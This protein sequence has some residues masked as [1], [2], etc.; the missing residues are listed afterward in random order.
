MEDRGT[1]E[2]QLGTE[3]TIK[4][5]MKEIAQKMSKLQR[6][7]IYNNAKNTTILLKHQNKRELTISDNKLDILYR[8]SNNESH[9]DN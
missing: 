4:L 2:I 7:R 9:N 1:L 6:F 3:I 5:K 8:A